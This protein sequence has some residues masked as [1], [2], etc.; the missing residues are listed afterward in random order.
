L[1]LEKKKKP[2]FGEHTYSAK[3]LIRE[4]SSHPDLLEALEKYPQEKSWSAFPGDPVTEALKEIVATPSRTIIDGFSKSLK[5]LWY[6][7]FNGLEIQGLSSLREQIKGKRVIYMPSHRSHLDYLLLSYVLLENH[8]EVPHIIAG[9]NLNIIGVGKI[10]R[11]SGAVFI[12]RAFRDQPIYATAFMTYLH[13][14]LDHRMPLEVFIEGGRS[15]TGKNMPPKIGFISILIEYFL[16]NPDA[17]LS[18]VPVSFTYERIPEESSYVNELKGGQKKQENIFELLKAYKV[19][20]K[21][22]GRVYVSFAPVMSLRQMMN[23]YTKANSLDRNPEP[24]TPEFKD[25]AYSFGMDVL[26]KINIYTRISA[27]PIVV[28]ALLSEKHRGFLKSN[29]LQKSQFLLDVYQAVHPRAQATLVESEG[30]LEGVIDFLIQSGT[31]HCVEEP[32]EDIYYFNSNDK[33]RLNLYKNIFVHHFVI[34]SIIAMKIRHGVKTREGL[35][36]HIQF[37][38]NLLRYEFMFSKSYDFI[39]ATDTMLKF[40]LERQLIIE[41]NGELL[42]NPQKA[43]QL[44]MLANIILPFLESFHVA[45]KTLTSKKATFPLDFN[46]LITIFRENHQNYLLLGEISSIEGNLTVSY[47]NII[48]F[49]SEEK[50]L[51]S[52]TVTR[53]KTI[54]KK[55]PE[56]EKIEKLNRKLFPRM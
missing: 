17:D 1:K 51:N 12:R 52:E 32:D 30:G 16:K 14:L 13:Y 48:R 43:V 6:R 28:T 15:R 55:G 49:F 39:E 23:T 22:F 46:K 25:M 42:A 54:I 40:S 41:Q 20:K 19:L 7:I 10:L 5:P 50:V 38:E 44:E 45:I 35:L 26:E 33:I 56:F 11:S 34:P 9:N 36:E 3:K 24:D 8:M 18:F 21:N 4:L 37:F 47:K 31:V 27:L 29:L 53:K 2:Y